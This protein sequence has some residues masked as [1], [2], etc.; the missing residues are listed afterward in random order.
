MASIGSILAAFLAGYQPKKIPINVQTPKL[1]TMLH[2]WMKM[3]IL[4]ATLMTYAAPT[5]NMTPITP[6]AIL[7]MAAVS[8][9]HLDVYKRQGQERT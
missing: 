6:P 9:T 3:G 4:A 7:S 8:Y 2:H 5:P 1:I